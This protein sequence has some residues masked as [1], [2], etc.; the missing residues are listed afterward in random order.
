MGS[1]DGEPKDTLRNI[2][3]SGEFVTNSVTADLLHLA[4]QSSA[5]YAPG[6]S[7]A[8]ELG[9]E[10][11]SSIR[12]KAPRIASAAVSL[13]CRLE[14]LIPLNDASNHNLVIGRVLCYRIKDEVFS[15]GRIDV[16]KF[17]A[18]GR[19]GGPFYAPLVN[20]L[21]VDVDHAAA[22]HPA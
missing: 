16:D 14:R 1:R 10:L 5:N 3:S 20:V 12:V 19:L 4:A 6:K 15:D 21:R 2:M 9:V 8:A 18:V 11:A 13:E 17:R 7:E 22:H